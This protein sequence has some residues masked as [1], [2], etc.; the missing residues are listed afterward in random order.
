MDIF[1]IKMAKLR[2]TANIDPKDFTIDIIN[3]LIKGES[4]KEKRI[5]EIKYHDPQ[6]SFTEMTNIKDRYID[7]GYLALLEERTYSIAIVIRR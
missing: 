4:E 2:K 5:Y 1:P 6:I 3:D 7:A